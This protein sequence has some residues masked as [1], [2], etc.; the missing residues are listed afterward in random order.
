MTAKEAL[1]RDSLSDAIKTIENLKNES[2]KAIKLIRSNL[3]E[4]ELLDDEIN[5]EIGKISRAL[6]KLDS[7]LNEKLSEVKKSK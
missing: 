2:S 1:I 6:N 4:V 5:S 7:I 3:T